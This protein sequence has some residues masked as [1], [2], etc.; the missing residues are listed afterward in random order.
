MLRAHK[1]TSQAFMS[2]KTDYNVKK[3]A[4]LIGAGV[5][6]SWG[7]SG[8]LVYYSFSDPTARGT[9]GD[10]FGA[11]NAL[12]SGLA[13]TGVITALI[14]QIQESKEQKE[15][16]QRSRIA[17]EESVA[18]LKLQM[19]TTKFHIQIEALNHIIDSLNDQITRTKDSRTE[20][21]KRHHAS[22]AQIRSKYESDLRNLVEIVLKANNKGTTNDNK[23]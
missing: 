10:M 2:I 14:M 23:Q 6:I 18:A 11:I 17:Q 16:I 4:I 13:L 7:G 21:E 8:F 1:V 22:L 9:F 19:E 5:L 15:D 12:F 3:W 20:G